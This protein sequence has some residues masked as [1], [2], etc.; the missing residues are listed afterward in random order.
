MNKI[1]LHEIEILTILD[2]H[3]CDWLILKKKSVNHKLP[4]FCSPECSQLDNTVN[5]LM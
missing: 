2:L 3:F 1:F 4:S 5:S